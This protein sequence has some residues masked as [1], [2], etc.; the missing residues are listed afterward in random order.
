MP[1]RLIAID[2]DGTLLH[3]DMTISSYSKEM[4]RRAMAKGYRIVVATGRMWDSAKAKV[5]LLELGNVPVICYTGAWI[6]MS[7]T[8]EPVM[9]DGIAP[10]LAGE[11]LRAGREAGWTATAFWNGHIY[12]EKSDGTEAK[13]QKY[14]TQ[15][16]QYLGEDFYHPRE[17]VTRIVFTDPT[18]EGRDRIRAFLEE[19]F[20]NEITVVYPGDDFVDIHKKG[21]HKA[22][23]LQYLA[24]KEG[25]TAEEVLAF[26]NTEN[27]VSML[28]W[29][30]LS[31][32]VANADE[33]AK[34]AADRLCPSNEEDGVAKALEKLLNL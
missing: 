16:P 30:G 23:A 17:R 10:E 2:L 7:G 13:Y 15:R 21:I 22:S 11:I 25:F 19:R 5:A 29:A 24:D 12:M 20:G 3:D 14:R 26:G 4:I 1:I 31:Y 9:Q 18:Q 27:D 8:D 34:E 6:M 28:R 33:V 32:A